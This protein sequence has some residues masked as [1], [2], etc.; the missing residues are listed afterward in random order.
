MEASHFD[1][2]TRLFST[3]ASRRQTIGA[4]VSGVL[5][6]TLPGAAGGTGRTKQGPATPNGASLNGFGCLDVGQA[7]KNADEC[8]SGRCRGKGKKHCKAHDTGGCKAG[9]GLAVTLPCRASPA[10]AKT[11]TA[12]RPPAMPG[13]A[14]T[15]AAAEVCTRDR[16][17]QISA[18]TRPPPASSVRP[19]RKAP[20]AWSPDYGPCEEHG[21][22]PTS[23]RPTSAAVPSPP[24][25]TGCSGRCR[26][27]HRPRRGRPGPRPILT[28]WT[29]RRIGSDSVFQRRHSSSGNATYYSGVT[30]HITERTY[31]GRS[32]HR[33]SD[34]RLPH[35]HPV[36]K[37]ALQ[38]IGGAMAVAV[39]SRVPP[40]AEAGK[41]RKPPL[42][43]ASVVLVDI[44]PSSGGSFVWLFQGAVVHKESGVQV[45]LNSSGGFAATH[46]RQARQELVSLVRFRAVEAL[47]APLGQDVPGDR[48][49]VILL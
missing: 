42:A 15:T 41:R 16:D 3:S 33:K 45:S 11:A 12:R 38:F 1:R 8:C 34:Q 2:M 46:D 21:A 44:R 23:C 26:S 36:R 43:V 25:T 31:D 27:S 10:R 35:R 32:I 5:V 19:A 6:V 28:G 30:N 39:P 7:C 18:N 14:R 9:E 13:S 17:C 37:R 49:A 29:S 47:R 48:I 40:A 24:L 4:L 22:S 20:P